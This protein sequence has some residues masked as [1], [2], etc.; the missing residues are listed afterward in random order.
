MAIRQMKRSGYTREKWIIVKN[1]R[2]EPEPRRVKRGG[3]I[4]D[5]DDN[6]IGRHWPL[7]LSERIRMVGKPAKRRA[8]PPAGRRRGKRGKNWMKHRRAA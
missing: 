5:P 6:P 2:G 7:R 4:T 3:E 1:L 8:G